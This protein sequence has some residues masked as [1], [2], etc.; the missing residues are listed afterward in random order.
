MILSN[1]RSSAPTVLICVASMQRYSSR[2]N[3]PRGTA[4]QAVK[5]RL[6]AEGKALV[7]RCRK[8]ANL[9]VAT[10]V[11]KPYL[12]AIG[13]MDH[14]SVWKQDGLK[15]Y[16]ELHLQQYLI[17]RGG[18]VSN[19]NSLE[20][21]FAGQKVGSP[22]AAFT[23]RVI[24]VVPAAAK[25]PATIMTFSAQG[26]LSSPLLRTQEDNLR[27]ALRDIMENGQQLA[28]IDQQDELS[29]GGDDME[30]DSDDDWEDEE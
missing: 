18:A 1:A 10:V 4:Q 23:G 3:V 27:S 16:D 13:M 26:F 19:I 7:A 22:R 5:D 28:G 11:V 6:I 9:P 8:L 24:V 20:R 21:L 12:V 17:V 29:D 14:I 15:L 30:D 2:S 25:A